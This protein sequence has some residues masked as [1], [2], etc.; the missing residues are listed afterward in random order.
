MPSSLVY[1]PLGVAVHKFSSAMHGKINSKVIG[2]AIMVGF[3]VD[4]HIIEIRMAI[5]RG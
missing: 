4:S 1:K 5:L 3:V 2:I